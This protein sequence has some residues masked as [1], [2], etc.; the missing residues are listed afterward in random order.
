M[1]YATLDQLSERFGEQMLVQLTDRASPP[2]GAIDASVV[3]R[4]LADTDAMIDGYLAGRYVLPLAET[5]DLLTDLALTIAIY[6][7]HTFAPDPKIEKDYELALKSLRDIAA[8]TIRLNVAG[9][10]PAAS[11]NSGVVTNDRERPL[12]EQTLKGYI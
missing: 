1:A 8:G 5:P 6:K 11:G 12:T 7:L 2:A 9:L 4:A 10:E 3:T